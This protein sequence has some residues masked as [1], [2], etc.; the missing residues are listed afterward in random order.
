MAAKSF[1][2]QSFNEF[3]GHERI[4]KLLRSAVNAAEQR[5]ELPGHILLFGPPGCGK[6]TLAKL[7]AGTTGYELT[8][9]E[10]LDRVIL[11]SEK[12][13]LIVDEIHRLDTKTQE[14]LYTP[15]ED[16]YIRKLGRQWRRDIC[17]I[18]TTT[19]LDQL[20]RAFRSRFHLEVYVPLYTVPEIAQIVQQAAGK[21]GVRV[22]IEDTVKIAEMARGTPRLALRV[23]YRVRDIGA[24]DRALRDVGF[25]AN[26]LLPEEQKY[27][28]C[29]KDLG[30]R[31]GIANI[32]SA[33]NMGVQSV[34]ELEPFLL[35]KGHI[36]ITGRG[37]LLTLRE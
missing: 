31:S 33:M 14:M 35:S 17:V 3:I 28:S 19:E 13:T 2:P 34:K 26:G 21:M 7:V 23:L 37:R 15:M 5:D 12:V 20:S 6:T 8:D 18:G 9:L 32:A 11:M 30:G 16:G 25:D 10:A 27:L 29:L 24:V 1:R 36:R 4:V 22:N